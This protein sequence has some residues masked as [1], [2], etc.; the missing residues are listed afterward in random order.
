[1]LT[2]RQILVNSVPVVQSS[3]PGSLARH[4]GKPAFTRGY[5]GQARGRNG[6]TNGV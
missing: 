3:G 2:T 1:V 6:A 4:K 5:D